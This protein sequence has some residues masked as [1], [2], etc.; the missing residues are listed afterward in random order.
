M[1]GTLTDSLLLSYLGRI[2]FSVT[3]IQRVPVITHDPQWGHRHSKVAC[4][5]E[6]FRILH[7]M[8]LQTLGIESFMNLSL[9]RKFLVVYN[10]VIW[11]PQMETVG[12][13]VVIN[14]PAVSFCGVHMM[15][16]YVTR[17]WNG[18][19]FSLNLMKMQTKILWLHCEMILC[20]SVRV[21]VAQ[22][23]FKTSL[24]SF[25]HKQPTRPFNYILR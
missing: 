18:L 4:L 8:L 3:V 14:E 10:S 17:N 19:R 13:L 12:T 25:F 1:D 20:G 9:Y 2:V 5:H 11:E 22:C 15:Q 7:F 23:K 24:R 16:S 21:V 6:I